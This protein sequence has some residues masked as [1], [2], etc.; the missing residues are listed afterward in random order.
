[1]TTSTLA[2]HYEPSEQSSLLCARELAFSAEKATH[3]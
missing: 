3:V 2:Q 1:M